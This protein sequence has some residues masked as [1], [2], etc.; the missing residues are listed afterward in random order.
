MRIHSIV[1]SD[2]HTSKNSFRARSTDPKFDIQIDGKGWKYDSEKGTLRKEN[3]SSFIKKYLLHFILGTGIVLAPTP[4]ERAS[5]YENNFA[6]E[7]NEIDK[8]NTDALNKA[9]QTAIEISET[10][11]E[12]IAKSAE[13]I[14]Q[15]QKDK[16]FEH[17]SDKYFERLYIAPQKGELKAHPLYPKYTKYDSQKAI[18]E[19]Q[20]L[21]KS[22]A[23]Y[24]EDLDYLYKFILRDVDRM[25]K[26]LSKKMNKDAYKFVSD[27]I[28]EKK[29][30]IEP[31]RIFFIIY[32]EHRYEVFNG[33]DPNVM[34][35]TGDDTIDAINKKRH[36]KKPIFPDTYE[37]S[38]KMGIDLLSMYMQDA[39]KKFSDRHTEYGIGNPDELMLVYYNQGPG[40]TERKIRDNRTSEFS[41]TY[42][43]FVEGLVQTYKM[44]SFEYAEK[45]KSKITKT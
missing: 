39:N 22:G 18:T 32:T 27:Y 42:A 3:K 16:K 41:K 19:I 13:A 20:R 6:P 25:I 2:L 37:N 29:Y 21:Q 45:Q 1:H 43:R 33:D 10:Q 17:D 35:I 34:Q 7:L 30:N 44:L 12:I 9:A 4:N 28:K 36:S 11:N 26:I 23:M 24:N 40:K 5:K 15:Q 14:K 38:I 31:M 8:N